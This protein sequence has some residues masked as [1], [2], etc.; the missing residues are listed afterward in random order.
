MDEIDR[1]LLH[2]DEVRVSA[3]FAANVM[4]EIR[5]ATNL[6]SNIIA[7]LVVGRWV[8][9]IDMDVA[10]AELAAGFVETDETLAWNNPHAEMQ[11][12]E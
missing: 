2:D 8:G 5:A 1:V 4:A 12:A 9:A 3:R 11:A 6:T 10:R 7:T